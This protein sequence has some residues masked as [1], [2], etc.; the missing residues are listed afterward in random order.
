MPCSLSR[1][2]VSLSNREQGN[3]V[4]NSF[5]FEIYNFNKIIILN[6]R[7]GDMVQE[8]QLQLNYQ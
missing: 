1:I 8:K 5:F 3:W 6:E 4:S 2:T 7:F